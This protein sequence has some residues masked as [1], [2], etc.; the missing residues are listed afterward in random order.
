MLNDTDSDYIE[1]NT[2]TTDESSDT[3]N[4]TTRTRRSYPE[5][6]NY[7]ELEEEV[8]EWIHEYMQWDPLAFSAPD[9]EETLVEDIAEMCCDSWSAAGREYDCIDDYL[10]WVENLLENYYDFSDAFPR[11]SETSRLPSTVAC[12]DLSVN[13]ELEEKI[14]HLQTIPQPKQR[15]PEWYEFR[16]NLITASNLW[17]VF[18]TPATVNSLICEKCRSSNEAEAKPYTV[19]TNSPMHWGVKYEPATLMIYEKMFHTRVS[20]FGCIPHR[21]ITCIG[22]S[23]DGINTDAGNPG[24]YGRM[25]EIKNIWN[26]EITGIPKE[27]YWI[28]IQTQLETCDLDD[29]DFVE[30]RIKEYE[31]EESFYSETAPVGDLWRGVILH[32]VQSTEGFQPGQGSTYDPN[33]VYKYMPLTDDDFY[34]KQEVNMWME[35]QRFLAR[36][37]NLVLFQPIYWYLD[38]ISCVLVKRNRPWFQAAE[39]RIRAVWDTIKEERVSGY[40]HRLPRKRSKSNDIIVEAA[41]TGVGNDDQSHQIR[42]MPK[43]TM[44]CLIKL[45]SNGDLL[46]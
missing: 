40:E 23:P 4:R 39:P 41:D 31:T 27:E 16:N 45:D 10:E 8:L 5:I 18:G 22:A 30:T 19:N 15:T 9:F 25:V 1:T 43:N 6:T 37:E 20:D 28:Q 33:P 38:E 34:D 11:R 14:A 26:R 36:A 32:F 2:T 42:N 3:E 24:L 12:E 13:P 44:V 17:K 35:E 21:R 7:D 46:A 29:C